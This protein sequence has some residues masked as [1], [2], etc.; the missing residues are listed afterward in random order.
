M[1]VRKNVN[2]FSKTVHFF[3]KSVYFLSKWS[4]RFQYE[5]G[6]FYAIIVLNEA[7]FAG[8]NEIKITDYWVT[9]YIHNIYNNNN[10]S[11]FAY[12]WEPQCNQ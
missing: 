4:Q 1:L 5:N 10:I 9:E 2:F 11:N 12:Q 8:E 6:G 7:Y 3:S